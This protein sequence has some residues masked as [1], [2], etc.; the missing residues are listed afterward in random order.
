M[1]QKSLLLIG[2]AG[3]FWFQPALS[4]SKTTVIQISYDD[5]LKMVNS[6]IC[7]DRVPKS[8]KCSPVQ[9]TVQGAP[10]RPNLVVQCPGCL[11][12]LKVNGA[13]VFGVLKTQQTELRFVTQAPSVME[14]MEEI[15]R[16]LNLYYD[17]NFFGQAARPR[18]L[19][20]DGKG[21]L[22]VADFG[23]GQQD[24]KVWK[25]SLPMYDATT[26]P[27]HSAMGVPQVEKLPSISIQAATQGQA[28][29]SVVGLSAVRVDGPRMVGL[30]NRV[31]GK[32][33]ASLEQFKDFPMA[34]LLRLAPRPASV[35]TIASSSAPLLSPGTGNSYSVIASLYDFEAQHDPD[36]RGIECNPFDFVLRG[37]EVYATDAAGNSVVRINL[38]T[39][40]MALYALFEQIPNP[41][42]PQ[43]GPRT[44]DAVPTGIEFGPDG[45]LYVSFVSGFP[46]VAG[47]AGVYR[48]KD[49]NGDGDALD[50]GEKTQ[51]VEGLTMAIDVTFDSHGRMYTL[52]HSLDFSNRGFGRICQIQGGRCGV[53]LAD[54][55]IAPTGLVVIH[56]YLYYSQEFTGQV[57]RLSLP[58]TK[59]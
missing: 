18:G 15:I 28:F 40:K 16:P 25:I 45:A 42:F 1:L 36:G 38:V 57:S 23:T 11:T 34:T 8:M 2:I 24:G 51:M 56:N 58:S 4:A 22:L 21:H 44:I 5:L 9:V 30:V 52:E 3:L 39:G 50:A 14:A 46:F 35:P 31:R 53:I 7:A 27:L 29:K 10:A 41:K 33:G 12:K 26:P 43:M 17:T 6:T 47:N 48:L 37:G 32:D 13:K 20:T 54:K 55:V 19:A 49:N 59:H